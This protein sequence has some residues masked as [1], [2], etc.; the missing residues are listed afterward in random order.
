MPK[1]KDI[2]PLGGESRCAPSASSSG[3]AGSARKRVTKKP[4]AVTK[5]P[6]AAT[7]QGATVAQAAEGGS[8]AGA[9]DGDVELVAV[10]GA[11]QPRPLAGEPWACGRCTLLN[12]SLAF[13]CEACDAPREGPT[14]EPQVP[15]SGG[16]RQ[17]RR[18][19]RYVRKPSYDVE[20]RIERAMGQ[21]LYLLEMERHNPG[22]GA[23]FAVLGS[24]GNVYTVDLGQ[25]PSC[26][27]PDFRRGRCVCKHV[28]FVWLR[29]LRCPQTD[30]R[31]WQNALLDSELESA[32]GPLFAR[33]ARRL[34][35]ATK[36]VLEAYKKVSGAAGGTEGNKKQ[37]EEDAAAPAGEGRRCRKVLEDGEE[38]P[39]CFE[40][41]TPD[42]E[43]R[44]LLSFCLSCGNN[45]HRDCIRRWQGASKGKGTCPL[46]REPWEAPSCTVAPG[47]PLPSPAAAASS[48][49]SVPSFGGAYLNLAAYR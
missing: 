41:M 49:Q 34:P 25:R 24:T 16:E 17:E 3:P 10:S 5:K 21:R 45:L 32:L 22:P 39:V 47:E 14:V 46:C 13:C 42:E 1:R 43:A 2:V 30:S 23:D 38:C 44:S 4:A 7:R 6:A 37:E 9:A 36:A 12:S 20:M 33:R 35:L 31:I 18:L 15:F 48:S 26:D 28:L 19:A 11:G 8:G 27:C 40:A 29:V